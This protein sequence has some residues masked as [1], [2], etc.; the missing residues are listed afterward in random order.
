MDMFMDLEVITTSAL[1]G[2]LVGLAF[3]TLLLFNGRFIEVSKIIHLPF[4]NSIGP[5][6]WAYFFILGLI[7]SGFLFGHF[8][9]EKILNTSTRSLL[10][11]LAGGLFCGVACSLIQDLVPKLRLLNFIGLILLY[12]GGTTT[13]LFLKWAGWVL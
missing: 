11:V 8:H 5:K 1:G 10:E 12:L 13:L 4:R 6:S 7:A 3:V 2:F 9:P